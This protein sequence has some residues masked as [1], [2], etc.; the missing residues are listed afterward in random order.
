MYLLLP[1]ASG[2]V[3]LCERLAVS[4]DQLFAINFVVQPVLVAPPLYR[5]KGLRPYAYGIYHSALFQ[6]IF[7]FLAI[8]TSASISLRQPKVDEFSQAFPLRVK[9]NDYSN[10]GYFSRSYIIGKSRG[11]VVAIY[12][13]RWFYTCQDAHD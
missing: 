2:I 5:K 7:P 1:C 12:S 13:E 8:D 6:S 11:S 9:I 3:V 10:Q 4:V